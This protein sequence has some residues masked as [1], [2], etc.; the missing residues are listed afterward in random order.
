MTPWRSQ[1]SVNGKRGKMM[2]MVIKNKQKEMRT[3]LAMPHGMWDLFP[4]NRDQ[5]H[6]LA[7][8][9]QRLNHWSAREV[10]EH[11]KLSAKS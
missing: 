2:L 4:P 8:E 10:P 5:I 7:S 1:C 9:G 11:F 6:T 3:F